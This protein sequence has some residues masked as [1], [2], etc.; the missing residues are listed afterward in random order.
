MKAR[1]NAWRGRKRGLATLFINARITI[2]Y[3]RVCKRRPEDC[4][5]NFI[6][7]I[8]TYTRFW[9]ICG[10][11]VWELAFRVHEQ[12]QMIAAEI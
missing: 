7:S 12:R 2:V 1:E 4:R 5:I 8:A 3:Y 9:F 6:A 10:V 11:V